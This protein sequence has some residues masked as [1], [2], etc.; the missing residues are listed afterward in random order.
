LAQN[1]AGPPIA[2]D[3]RTFDSRA[4]FSKLAI[5]ERVAVAR[6]LGVNGFWR[7]N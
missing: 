2:A 5:R 7:R 1:Y 6:S 3:L 4:P